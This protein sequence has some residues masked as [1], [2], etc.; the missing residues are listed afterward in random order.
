MLRYLLRSSLL[1][2]GELQ[3]AK[4]ILPKTVKEAKSVNL[5]M[6]SQL[7]GTHLYCRVNTTC[8]CLLK[9]TADPRSRVNGLR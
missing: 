9:K 5:F 8:W 4:E 2:S 6:Q 7:P 1:G 3:P